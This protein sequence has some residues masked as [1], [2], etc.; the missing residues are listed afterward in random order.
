MIE[1][2]MTTKEW[3]DQREFLEAKV[4]EALDELFAL[5][6]TDSMKGETPEG[7]K[8]ATGSSVVERQNR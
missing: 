6:G 2:D 3:N 8:F 7:V 4:G 5:M 1:E